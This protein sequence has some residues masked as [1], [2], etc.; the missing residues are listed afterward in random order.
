MYNLSGG[1]EIA[2]GSTGT[3]TLSGQ[4][5]FV[6]YQLYCNDVRVGGARISNQR[7]S[8]LRG[9][10]HYRVKGLSR[11]S[12][13]LD[14]RRGGHLAGDHEERGRWGRNDPEQPAR[15]D[16]V[17]GIA[18]HPDL[19]LVKRGTVVASR[20]GTGRGSLF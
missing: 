12:R 17:T 6:D 8:G 7:F 15:L 16:N 2:E 18:V 20:V 3:V 9:Y 14:E 11:R 19:P 10:G 1:G 4:Q 5:P 13:G